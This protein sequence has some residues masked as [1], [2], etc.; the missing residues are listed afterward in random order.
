MDESM[1]TSMMNELL[2]KLNATQNNEIRLDKLELEVNNK[3][4][5]AQDDLEKAEKYFKQSPVTKET[6][7]NQVNLE[8]PFE[9]SNINE[10]FVKT[11]PLD[12]A[13]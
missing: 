1:E 11:L 8:L 5:K 6:N 12:A 3:F 7:V 13:V 9:H 4:L 2:E 10:S